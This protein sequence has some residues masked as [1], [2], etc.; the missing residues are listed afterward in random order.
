MDTTLA[1]LPIGQLLDGRYRVDARI[2][3]GG[4]ATV[5]LG[6]DTRLERRVALKV[7]HPEFASDEGFVG[8]FIDE[9]R[10]VAKLSSPNVVAVFDQ[11][12]D[13]NILYLAMEYV[14][15]RTLRQLLTERGRLRPRESLD[16]I[17]GVL[18]GLSAAHESGIIHRDV[19]PENVLITPGNAVKVAD[20]GLARAAARGGHTQDGMIIGTAAYLAPEQV[21]QSASDARTDVYATGIMLFELLTG[22]QPHRGETPLAVAYKHV[23]NVVPSPSS[24]APGLPPALD[25]LVALATSRNPDRRPADAGQFLRAI[26]EVRR[27]MPLAGS[28]A[29]DPAGTSGTRAGG[30]G[31]GVSGLDPALTPGSMA[32]PLPGVGS[33]FPPGAASFPPGAAASLPPGY[34]AAPVPSP[35]GPAATFPPGGVHADPPWAEPGTGFPP[36]LPAPADPLAQ[37]PGTGGWAAVGSQADTGPGGRADTGGWA[38]TGSRA[39]SGGRAEPRHGRPAHGRKVEIL[40]AVTSG[41]LAAVPSGA[42]PMTGPVGTGPGGM[43]PGGMGPGGIGPGGMGP[44]TGAPGG[45]APE[46]NVPLDALLQ[47]PRP[48][49]GPQDGMNHTLIVS[50]A[51]LADGHH[52]GRADGWGH[53]PDGQY[54]RRE[55]FLQRWLFSRRLAYVAAALA[56]IIVVGLVT[57]WVTSGRFSTVPQV[58]GMA[59]STARQELKNLGFT[60]HMG[61]GVRSNQVSRGDVISTSPAIGARARKGSVI[62]IIPSL[63]PIRAKVP[64]VTGMKLSDAEAALQKAG[65]KPGRVENSASPTIPVGVVISTSPE[66]GKTWPET[67]PVTI[68]QSAGPPLP[69]L[70]GQQLTAAQQQAQQFGFQVNPVNDAKSNLPTGTIISQ[71][72]RPGGPITQGEVVTIRVSTGPQLV[73]VPNVEGMSDQQAIA[74]LQQAGFQVNVNQQGFG[75]RVFSYSPSGQ[76]PRGSTINIFLGF[77][78]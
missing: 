66:A 63:G 1:G 14:P 35:A 50:G 44:A 69:N 70:V 17:E 11:G 52:G 15:G 28:H 22:T 13:G 68:V 9:A 49:A 60:V 19:K 58:A 62:T 48:A 57:W 21:S 40:P 39:D 2:A 12:A 36:V 4:M 61:P 55:P 72:P 45:M 24:L 71:S 56:V 67:R 6:T 31:L 75:H 42:G 41:P 65:L 25:A 76:A 73:N 38:A 16:I 59:K 78:F 46:G 37:G 33:G 53:G 30:V 77:G 7:A 26:T 18:A 47:G 43:G 20:F 34:A 23:D 54:G 29:G 8:R 27:G 74:E 3:R 10:S 5:Y 32:G 51:G 64:S